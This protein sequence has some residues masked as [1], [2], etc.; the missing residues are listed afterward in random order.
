[1][2]ADSFVCG[3][4]SK[5]MRSYALQDRRSWWYGIRDDD[6]YG[7]TRNVTINTTTRIIAYE[8]AG[9]TSPCCKYLLR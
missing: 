5:L 1:M 7:W 2:F 6:S 3:T 9:I 4:V 8:T